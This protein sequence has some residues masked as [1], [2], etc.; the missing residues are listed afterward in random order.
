MRSV[1]ISSISE[2]QRTVPTSPFLLL[3]QPSKSDQKARHLSYGFFK[4]VNL[5]A[6]DGLDRRGE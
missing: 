6:S 2:R 5:A 3:L 1:T 4:F